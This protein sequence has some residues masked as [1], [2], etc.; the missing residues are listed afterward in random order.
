[1]LRC[2]YQ[3]RPARFVA[4]LIL[5]QE[6]FAMRLIKLFGEKKAAPRPRL[7]RPRLEMLEARLVLADCTFIGPSGGDW[8]LPGNWS[9]GTVP[10]SADTAIFN[11]QSRN[12]VASPS[13]ISQAACF[14]LNGSGFTGVLSIQVP[15][16]IGGPGSPFSQWTGGQLVQTDVGSSVGSISIVGDGARF[17]WKGAT[18]TA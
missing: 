5:P 15:L 8:G 12:C 1:M 11:A 10:T 17:I 7:A 18:W 2:C 13:L 16:T 9:T 4:S 14:Q 6:G 3:T